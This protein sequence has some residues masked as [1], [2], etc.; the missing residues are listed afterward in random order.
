MRVASGQRGSVSRS[1]ARALARAAVVGAVA[2]SSSLGAV[3]GADALAGAVA[4]GM[5]ERR[6]TYDGLARRYLLY[7]PRSY[8]G[9]RA[10]PLVLVLHGGSMVPEDMTKPKIGMVE[11]AERYGFLCA[12]PQAYIPKGDGYVWSELPRD[13]APPGFP[14]VDDHGFIRAVVEEIER[15]CR[16][17]WRR[18]Y[19]SGFSSG[20]KQTM[21]QG[22][23]NF[24]KF[25]AIATFGCAGGNKF[26]AGEPWIFPPDPP[27]PM[28][29]LMVNGK[30]D[31]KIPWYGETGPGGAE[32][33]SVEETVQFWV[34]ANACSPAPA[35]AIAP[36]ATGLVVRRTYAGPAGGDAVHVGVENLKHEWPA[37]I[38]GIRS[39]RIVADF[40]L[41][42]PKP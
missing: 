24:D 41:A 15:D 16:V 5:Q 9:T 11:A 42:H 21:W 30:A 17:D 10:V 12:Y 26:G 19:C 36:S 35:V 28:P 4:P 18:I 32:S 40:F 23:V 1:V 34:R 33:A 31:P 2:L 8:D 25:A 29:I 39:A 37:E 3:R 20:G 27:V 22:G 13:V 38:A 6:T 14:W 7:V